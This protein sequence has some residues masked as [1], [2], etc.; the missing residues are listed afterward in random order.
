MREVFRRNPGYWVKILQKLYT[1]L[2]LKD[3]TKYEQK[4]LFSGTSHPK[5]TLNNSIFCTTPKQK[6]GHKKPLQRLLW[7]VAGAHQWLCS[8][9]AAHR[10][11]A[12]FTDFSTLCVAP[13][14]CTPVTLLHCSVARAAPLLPCNAQCVAPLQCTPVCCSPAPGVLLP[15][16]TAQCVAP[17]QQC[18]PVT[19]P[20]TV[21]L[22]CNAHQWLCCSGSTTTLR[23]QTPKQSQAKTNTYQECRSRDLY[24][25]IK[26]SNVKSPPQSEVR[27][28]PA[29]RQNNA[30]P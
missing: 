9:G 6:R 20:H 5:W 21:L 12:P 22:H 11:A 17:L 19:F 29:Q 8:T 27:K 14:Q 18:T 28:T 2:P 4:C 3:A 24:R 25:N 13:L 16:Y 26:A 7:T 15:S 10:C 1:P 23:S 30:T